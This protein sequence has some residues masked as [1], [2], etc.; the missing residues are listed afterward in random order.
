MDGADITVGNFSRI[1]PFCWLEPGEGIKIGNHVG[2]GGHSLIFTH[3]V[4]SNF[5]QGGPVSFGPVV[6][7]DNVWLPWRVFV[8]PNVTIGANSIIGAN[9]TV[10]KSVPAHSLA[11]GSPAKVI[12]ENMR[13]E[14]SLEQFAKRCESLMSEYI[15]Y[16]KRNHI[17]P[18]VDSH[19]INFVS[20]QNT[21]GDG[22]EII[23]DID[24]SEVVNK[25]SADISSFIGFL[26]RYGIRVS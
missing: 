6:I 8:M 22:K 16:C 17:N 10:T 20:K 1:F 14:L 12:K 21:W 9:S 3:G 2:I 18:V 23:I 19:L 15:I 25:T 26:R 4:W 13:I 7:E 11:A 24:K 5:L